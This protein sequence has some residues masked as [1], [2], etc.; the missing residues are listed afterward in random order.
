MGDITPVKILIVAVIA[1]LVLGP[2]KLPE[3]TRKAGKAWADFRRFRENMTTQVRDTVGDVPGFSELTQLTKLTN[4]GIK[5][6]IASSVTAA[7]SA[8]PASAS[9]T[10]ASLTS[11]SLTSAPPASAISSPAEPTD[12][13]PVPTEA[14]AAPQV[15]PR[16]HT[17]APARPGMAEPAFAAD[18]PSFN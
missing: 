6:T 17:N 3:M 18:D 16:P 1:L 5:S 12:R 15:V 11:A 10:A 4:V 2:E 13:E 14:A 9:P 7:M 8:P